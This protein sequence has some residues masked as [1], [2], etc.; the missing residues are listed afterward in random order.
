MLKEQRVEYNSNITIPALEKIIE[1]IVD[2]KLKQLLNDPDYGLELRDE[3]KQ[4]LNKIIKR[5]SK[6][7]TEQKIANKYGVRF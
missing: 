3:F 5:N 4:K 6:P 7:I 1:R 2:R